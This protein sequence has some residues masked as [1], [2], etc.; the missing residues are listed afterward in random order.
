MSRFSSRLSKKTLSFTTDSSFLEKVRE[1]NE[2]AWFKFY[3][4]YSGLVSYIGLQRGLSEAECEDLMTDV[5]VVF[6]QK[7]DDFFY[8]RKRGKFRN[9]LSWI[10]HFM[11]LKIMRRKLREERIAA[12]VQEI[13]PECINCSEMEEFKNY[14]IAQALEDLKLCVDTETYEVFY[15]SFIQKRSVADISAITRKTANNIYVIRSRCL[16]RLKKQI[17]FYRRLEEEYQGSSS[18]NPP[19]N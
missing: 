16:K 18:R 3:R 19:A 15:M 9:Y 10:A 7:M 6:W 8:D 13:Y 2:K 5:M 4:K 14:L 11:S 17:A 12:Q 1:G